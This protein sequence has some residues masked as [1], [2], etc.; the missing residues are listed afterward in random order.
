VPGSG[1]PEDLSSYR[2]VVHCGAC[3]LNR[4]E[5]LR[6]QQ[7]PAAAKVPVTNYGVLIAF[8]KNVFPRALRP[9]PELYARCEKMTWPRRHDVIGE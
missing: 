8:L 4:R 1:Y 2:L 5:M 9:F 7:L 3:T 6:R